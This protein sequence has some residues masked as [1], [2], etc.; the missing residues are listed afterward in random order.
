MIGPLSR[1]V[2]HAGEVAFSH[3]SLISA[4]INLGRQLNERGELA[5][6]AGP[7]VKWSELVPPEG[8]E[9]CSG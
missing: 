8:G 4:A 9:P 3:L 6:S 5:G 2:H 1:V 7:V